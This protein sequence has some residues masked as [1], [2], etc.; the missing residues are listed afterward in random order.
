MLLH[1]CQAW[2]EYGNASQLD[3]YENIRSRSF[4]TLTDN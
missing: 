4:R 1:G 3:Q 2:M